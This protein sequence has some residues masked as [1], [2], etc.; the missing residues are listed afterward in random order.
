M[1]STASALAGAKAALAKANKDFGYEAKPKN[2]PSSTA[3]PK[4]TTKPATM[5][6]SSDLGKDLRWNAEQ[7]QHMRDTLHQEGIHVYHDGGKI[8]K[9]GAQIIVAEKGE[10]VLPNDKKKAKELAMDHLEGLKAGIAEG[11]KKKA[12]AKPHKEEKHEKKVATKRHGKVHKMHVEVADDG[13]FVM[14]HMHHPMEDGTPV[15]DTTHTAQDMDQLHDHM[16]E[17]LGQPAQ[18]EAEA[19]AGQHGVPDEMASQ[20]GLPSQGA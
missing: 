2:A 16:E 12:G 10:T 3:A 19:D 7:G 18:G 5:K 8:K 9:D 15:A 20:A 6:E 13:S 11:K 14:H 1:S 4:Q 17:H